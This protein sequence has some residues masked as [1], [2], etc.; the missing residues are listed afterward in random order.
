MNPKDTI[1]SKPR[2]NSI[3]VLRGFALMGILLLH[4]LEHFESY[5]LPKLESPFWQWIDTAIHDT[6]FFLFQGKSYAIFSLLFGLSFFM[7]LDSQAGKDKYYQLRY[8]WRLIV[9]FVFG[10]VNGLFYMGEWFIIYAMSGILLFP[11]HK[12]PSKVLIMISILFFLQI[13]QLVDFINILVHNTPPAPS[14]ISQQMS[15]L[16]REGYDIYAN[17]SLWNVLT[18]NA[19]QGRIALMLWFIN[20]RYQQ[21]IGLFIIGILI[22]RSRIYKDPDKMVYWSKKILPY[23]IGWFLLFYI[24]V[25]T[26][27]FF[28]LERQ[29]LRAGTGLLKTFGNL[30]MMMTYICGFTVLYYQT[31]RGYKMLDKL[32]AVG[33]MS[34]TNYMMQSIIGITIFYGFGLGLANQ[35][36]LVCFMIGLLLCTFQIWYSNWHFKRFYYGPMEWLWRTL[37]WFKKI[38]MKRLII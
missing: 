34:V 37:T 36:F 32:A 26:L 2:I 1:A 23:A 35:T 14:A 22:G 21:M 11:L 33:R 17:G 31:V 15:R 20:V 6:L 29:T 3:D 13:P 24:I 38:P 12:V 30:G 28:G 5:Y 27:P 16:F 18:F 7:Q 9:L 25:W 10:Y 4:C 8:I 19:V